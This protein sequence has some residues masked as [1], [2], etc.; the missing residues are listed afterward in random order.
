VSRFGLSLFPSADHLYK[1][2][3]DHI[4]LATPSIA[5]YRILLQPGPLTIDSSVGALF[6]VDSAREVMFVAIA[7]LEH[8]ALHTVLSVHKAA[9]VVAVAGRSTAGRPPLLPE[10]SPFRF[11]LL[12]CRDRFSPFSL[13]DCQ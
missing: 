2:V 3:H 12:L 9:V 13:R 5:S 11:E 4:H 6:A 7:A 8:L 10:L 1:V